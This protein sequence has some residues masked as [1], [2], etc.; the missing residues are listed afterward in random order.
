MTVKQLARGVLCTLMLLLAVN[1][2]GH[3]LSV[4]A[5][6]EGDTLLVETRFS[7]GKIPVSGTI[8]LYDGYD[9]K[10]SEHPI[11]GEDVVRLPLPAWESGLK[12]EAATGDGHD[13]YWILTPDDIRQQR[14]QEP[15]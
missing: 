4:F 7:S 6:V 9:E 12:V 5:W 11:T 13:N 15:Q 3:S 10:L 2:Y 14:E 8:T 1:A